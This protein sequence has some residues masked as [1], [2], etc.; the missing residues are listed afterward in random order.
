[1]LD[2]ESIGAN[3][4]IDCPSIRQTIRQSVDESVLKTYD[5]V[6]QNVKNFDDVK[7]VYASHHFKKL[8]DVKSAISKGHFDLDQLNDLRSFIVSV[9]VSNAKRSI[10]VGDNV[11]IVQKTKREQGVVVKVNIKKAVVEMRGGRYNVPLSMLELV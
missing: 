10:S 6:N 7:S 9:S 5:C 4:S 8:D 2:R 1:M 3:N 11:W